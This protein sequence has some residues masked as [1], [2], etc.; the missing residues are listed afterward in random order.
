MDASNECD[1]SDEL[2]RLLRVYS[3]KKSA[4]LR[5][6]N[7]NNAICL[8]SISIYRSLFLENSSLIQRISRD[9]WKAYSHI[10]VISKD[11]HYENLKEG[12]VAEILIKLTRTQPMMSFFRLNFR[13]VIN[14]IL[15]ES[16]NVFDQTSLHYLL[17]FM[18]E[19]RASFA[20]LCLEDKQLLRPVSNRT[21]FIKDYNREIGQDASFLISWTIIEAAKYCIRQKFAP[22][23]S[24]NDFLNLLLKET[25]T[26]IAPCDK[27]SK[28]FLL[29]LVQTLDKFIHDRVMQSSNGKHTFAELNNLQQ[30]YKMNS[31][32]FRSWF[33]KN[34][35]NI[36]RLGFAADDPAECWRNINLRLFLD[37]ATKFQTPNSDARNL[38]SSETLMSFNAKNWYSNLALFALS[39]K[40]LDN[41]SLLYGIKALSCNRGIIREFPPL[42]SM[43]SNLEGRYQLTLDLI[44]KSECPDEQSLIEFLD[45]CIELSVL[46]Q[47][48]EHIDKIK[49]HPLRQLYKM[50]SQSR[51]KNEPAD[52]EKF[53]EVERWLG[54]WS[55]MT[56]D[57]EVLPA[58][59]Y[60]DLMIPTCMN[61][62]SRVPQ[63]ERFNLI[64]SIEWL[65]SQDFIAQSLLPPYYVNNNIQVYYIL[66]NLLKGKTT[67]PL[68]LAN[69]HAKNLYWNHSVYRHI[70]D[71]EMID[72]LRKSDEEGCVDLIQFRAAKFNKRNGNLSLTKKIAEDLKLNAMT[73]HMKIKSSL[74]LIEDSLS[75]DAKCDALFDISRQ[76]KVANLSNAI[77]SDLTAKILRKFLRLPTH[78]EANEVQIFSLIEADETAC[79]IVSA[80][81]NAVNICK[82]LLDSASRS[83]A[84]KT[85]LM[86]ARRLNERLERLPQN[87]HLLNECFSL[88]LEILVCLCKSGKD[89]KFRSAALECGTRILNNIA[90]NHSRINQVN[91]DRFNSSNFE[92]CS[93]V[94]LLLKTNLVSIISYTDELPICWRVA[95][96]KVLKQTVES[97]PSSLIYSIIVNRLDLQDELFCLTND[98][99]MPPKQEPCS[100]LLRASCES[101][102]KAE[103]SKKIRDCQRKLAFWN[104]LLTHIKSNSHF[105][106]RW[107]EVV[108]E[109]EHF[110]KEIRK[111][112]FLYGDY[113]KILTIKIPRRLNNF[114]EYFVK[115]SDSKSGTILSKQRLEECEKKLKTVCDQASN[116]I[117]V[118]LNY[119][120]KVG[121]SRATDYDRYYSEKYHVDLTELQYR[122]NLLA[123]KKPLVLSS[124]RPLVKAITELLNICRA[125]LLS[126]NHNNRQKLYMELIS[127]VLSRLGPSLIPMPD[128]CHETSFVDNKPMI[129]IHKVSQTVNMISSK[130]C[131]KKLKFIGSDGITRSFLLKAHEDLR[132]DQLLME[133]FASINTLF[134]A[135]KETRDIFRL[136]R[137]SVTPV[138]SRS[139]LIQW[140]EAPSLCSS[141]RSW[142]DGP[143]GKKMVSELYASTC[144]VL[145]VNEDRQKKRSAHA[146]CQV[147]DTIQV[148]EIFYQLL[149]TKT[150]SRDSYTMLAKPAASNIIKYRTEYEPA[151]I[152][153][154]V[155]QMKMMTPNDLI[156]N[157]FWYRSRNSHSYWTKTQEFIRSCAAIS[158]AGYIIGLGDRH[159]EN[160][161]LDYETG[162]VIHIDLNICFELGK[163][164]SI[165]EKVPFRLTQNIIHAFGFAGL[166]GGFTHSCRNILKTL[167]DSKSTILHLLDPINL[168]F[169]VGQQTKLDEIKD[170]I[171]RVDS[172]HHQM[173]E[174]EID[175]KFVA[176][177]KKP[178]VKSSLRAIELDMCSQES[179]E[180]NRPDDDD[181]INNLLILNPSSGPPHVTV[182][183]KVAS[184]LLGT[185]KVPLSTHPIELIKPAKWQPSFDFQLN[186][187]TPTKILARAA[188]NIH[189]RIKDKLS[190]TDECICNYKQDSEEKQVRH[191]RANSSAQ[192]SPEAASDRGADLIMLTDTQTVEDQ[193]DALI[194][195]ALSIKN[196]AAMFEGW[197]PWV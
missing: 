90:T 4:K 161:L 184:S 125:S 79:A 177:P 193:V 103:P 60:I 81:D 133:V 6:L 168:S 57:A 19:L 174:R 40:K 192:R 100:V 141:Y 88:D 56:D 67:I 164:L 101:D 149:W 25:L 78:Q 167:K 9:A 151:V 61:V 187:K 18:N 136:R 169:M 87:D 50:Y 11:D 5:T 1:E 181:D 134:L 165:P 113:L 112:S 159:P 140:I 35:Q 26:P 162:E 38:P 48:V 2:I 80:G 34:R 121:K 170:N 59:S 194:F 180:L 176:V 8:P 172:F 196:M 188:S 74:L 63:D 64:E 137:Y 115:Y 145:C 73:D 29:N 51:S 129:T 47:H 46:D 104:E 142:L 53:K 123:N 77:K 99:S 7:G 31:A 105:E 94:W 102:T 85:L 93:A 185:S 82:A 190:G 191:S 23:M 39:A 36:A 22:G 127:P 58:K 33:S 150:F 72:K 106:Y 195:E 117:G 69:T 183:E 24:A 68:D 171:T 76:T 21:A 66:F 83:S 163:N 122:L 148:S 132:L 97:K 178:D 20:T 95:L 128:C 32:I 42:D 43:I 108:A 156:S 135:N 75:D 119:E 28:R 86:F 16:N 98:E 91:L 182:N 138:S 157:Q 70:C 139:G 146:N 107:Q 44:Q 30:F 111:I 14:F 13:Q 71:L 166:E 173:T 154:V 186:I 92:W 109:T 41:L 153:D 62:I 15:T 3:N 118:L 49:S 110:L 114:L 55:D 189:E 54:T 52:S 144:K 124:L 27:I 96:I 131:P 89:S 10:N 175:S 197:M 45:S 130:T 84:A 120:D 126:Y 152:E 143:N 37:L 65:I 155:E 147:P 179:V 116:A 12:Q 158:I 160:I 17:S